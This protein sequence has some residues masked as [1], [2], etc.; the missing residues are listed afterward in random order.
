[1][2]KRNFKFRFLGTGAFLAILAGFAAAVMFLWNALMPDIFGLPTLNYW[3]AAGLV[4]LA[5]VLLGGFLGELGGGRFM[6]H[7]GHS[8]DERLFHHGHALRE[9]WMNM[10]DEERKAFVEKERGFRNHFHDRFSHCHE[11]FDRKGAK[12]GEKHE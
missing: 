6:P 4:A 12:D 2:D 7:A 1:M 9:K 10:S 5:R 8:R 3:Q 11:C